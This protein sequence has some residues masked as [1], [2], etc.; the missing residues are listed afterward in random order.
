MT[1][2]LKGVK[3]ISVPAGIPGVLKESAWLKFPGI[4][5]ISLGVIHRVVLYFDECLEKCQFC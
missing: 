5:L 1:E 2:S 4:F 3:I